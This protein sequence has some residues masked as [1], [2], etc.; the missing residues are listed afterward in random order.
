MKSKA[1]FWVAAAMVAAAMVAGPAMAQENAKPEYRVE[2]VADNLYMFVSVTVPAGNI[3]ISA[4]DDGVFLIDDQYAPVT[5]EL[6]KAIAELSDQ[7]VRYLINTHYHLDHSGGNENL[8]KAGTLIVGHDNIRARLLTRPLEQSGGWTEEGS[9]YGL[10]IVTFDSELSLHLNGDEARAIHVAH[11]HTDG[12]AIIHFKKANVIHMGDL[13]FNGLFPFIDV[14][15]G[16]NVDGVLKGIDLALELA[17]KNTRIIPGHG[18][19][20]SK[21]DLVKYRAMIQ[22]VRDR[23]AML[24]ADGKSLEQVLEAGPTAEFDADWTWGFI[25]GPKF[26]T[27][28]FRSLEAE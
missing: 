2:K 9:A 5:P 19:L 6:M 1:G 23:V 20:A 14:D 3:G 16:G 22:T 18:P 13:M 8:G 28:I 24:R 27:A 10:P 21:D 12:D 25:D 17:D 7:P 11:A 4:G 15:S 26:V